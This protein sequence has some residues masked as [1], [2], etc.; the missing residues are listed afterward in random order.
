MMPPSIDRRG[1]CRKT[2]IESD[3]KNKNTMNSNE[4]RARAHAVNNEYH[5]PHGVIED[6][7]T[8]N[9]DRREKNSCENEQYRE[10]WREKRSEIKKNR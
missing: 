9:Q 1:E 8:W 3:K 10:A 4:H 6:L 5:P 7:V 2:R